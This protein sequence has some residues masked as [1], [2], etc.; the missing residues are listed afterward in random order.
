MQM[1]ITSGNTLH[2]D[3]ALV[4]GLVSQH[5]PMNAIANSVNTV[6]LITETVT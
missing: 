4:F 6:N 5:W 1:K 2:C 3:Y